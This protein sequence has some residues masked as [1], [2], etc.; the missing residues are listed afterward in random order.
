MLGAQ[1]HV[2]P[3]EQGQDVA[4]ALVCRK[5]TTICFFRFYVQLTTLVGFDVAKPMSFD[6]TKLKLGTLLRN[7]QKCSSDSK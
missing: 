1:A 3:V 5:G 2:E 6:T 7:T 4:Q